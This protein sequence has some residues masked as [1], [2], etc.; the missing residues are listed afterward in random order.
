MHS[1]VIR[2]IGVRLLLAV[3]T[4]LIVSIVVFAAT[5][6]LPGSAARAALG[7]K[8]DPSA[9]A[10]LSREFG[11]DRP[12]PERYWDWISGAVRGDFGKSI[13]S[14]RPV[15]EA[16]QP[17]AVNTLVL[18]V[19]ALALLIPLSFIL[20]IAAALR[21]DSVVDHFISVT[22]LVAVALPEFVIGTILIVVFAVW[23]SVLPPV[24]LVDG[25]QPLWAQ[26]N[27][28]VL[29]VLTLLGT[30]LA[31]VV[32]MV[33][34]VTLDVLDSEYIYM[35]RLKG[36][37]EAR[38]LRRHVFPNVISPTIQTIAL[39]AA[40]LAGGVVV[41]ETVF[42]MPGIGSALADAVISRDIPT[43]LAI[44][45]IITFAYV[46]INLVSE[47]LILLLNPRFRIKS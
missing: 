35:V 41:T 45:M 28:F 42:Q 16:I 1:L 14:G 9:V 29:P 26:A 15:W 21:K 10:A 44:A 37:S 38:V 11:L 19:A 5:N 32:R 20:G 12:A 18:T 34:A 4:L 6:L 39:N 3:G 17:K 7:A 43:V 23:W 8:A 25:S 31:Q 2:L 30:T 46:L 47:V 33:R 13:P 40:W 36:I 22:T 27:V 24:S